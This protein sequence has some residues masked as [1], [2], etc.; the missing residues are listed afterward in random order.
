MTA[1]RYRPEAL[2]DLDDIWNYI[3]GY[4]P[5][6]ANNY[7]DGLAASV[8]RLAAFPHSGRSRDDLMRG[9]RSLGYRRHVTFYLV[10][11]GRVEIVRVQ[12]ASR[13]FGSIFGS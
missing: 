9:L 3:A 1:L 11:L 7:M 8:A 5:V 4:D 2:D 12:H 10:V 13:D 6:A